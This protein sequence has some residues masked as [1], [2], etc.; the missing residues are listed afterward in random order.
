MG[1]ELEA[2]IQGEEVG[3]GLGGGGGGSE[4]G[5]EEVEELGGV[6]ALEVEDG[7]NVRGELLGVMV[8]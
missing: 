7:E 4:G 1:G 2:G 6:R 5:G 8:F 3:E